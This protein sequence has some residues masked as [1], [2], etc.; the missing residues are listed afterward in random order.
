MMKRFIV[1]ATALAAILLLSA[2][3][4]SHARVLRSATD[5]IGKPHDSNVCLGSSQLP[6]AFCHVSVNNCIPGYEPSFSGGNL[7][8][9]ACEPVT[10]IGSTKPAATT[11]AEG[12]KLLGGITKPAAT[13]SKSKKKSFDVTG[14]VC[15][16]SS[17][18]PSAFC[19]VSVNNCIP[20]YK[21]S[22]SGG[23]LCICACEPVTPIGSTKPVASSG[24]NAKGGKVLGGITK[25]T[26]TDA[27][28]GKLLD[29]EG[30]CIF[31]TKDC[32][33]GCSGK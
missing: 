15:S 13:D 30:R 32:T 3:C 14:N 31:C 1:L 21:P 23:N 19:Q 33:E 10:P 7:C 6:S 25:T 26:A 2:T 22:F 28:S 5:E 12:G 20:G 18:L 24:T 27:K 16:G 8:I 9:C 4:S 29:A 11:D 17:Q